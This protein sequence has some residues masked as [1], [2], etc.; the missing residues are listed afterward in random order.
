MM[1]RLVLVSGLEIALAPRCVAVPLT[2]F[3]RVGPAAFSSLSPF[4][5]S[6]DLGTAPASDPRFDRRAVSPDTSA[7]HYCP[8]DDRLERLLSD[9][10]QRTRPVP[11]AA[12]RE[13][14]RRPNQM[15]EVKHCAEAFA[16][17]C[18]VG[19]GRQPQ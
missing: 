9:E 1:T 5:A 12:P 16:P 10:R 14:S 7:T 3:G 15:A 11:L 17:R 4:S 8:P 6:P 2:R 18:E 13:L 19:N